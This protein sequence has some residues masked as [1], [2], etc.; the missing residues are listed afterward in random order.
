M[1]CND[2]FIFNATFY[3]TLVTNWILPAVGGVKDFNVFNLHT[4]YVKMADVHAPKYKPVNAA[5]TQ[6][7]HLLRIS[8]K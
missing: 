1:N 4:N 8:N 5:T 2:I 6:K 3:D 7:S